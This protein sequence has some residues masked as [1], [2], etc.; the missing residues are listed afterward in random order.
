MTM[1]R[2]LVLALAILF[3][4]PVFADESSHD[5]AGPAAQPAPQQLYGGLGDVH[6]PVTTKSAQAQKYFDEGLA[7]NY[8]FN[9]NEAYQSFAAAAALDPKMAMANWGIALVFGPNYNL[10]G[11]DE[12]MKIA[13]G[14]IQRAQ[15]LEASANP[16]EKALIEALAKRYG[17]DGKQTPQREKA[18]A[19][20]MRSVANKYP[21][22]PDVQ[23][24]FAESLMDL[25]PWELWG[26][27]GKPGPQTLELVDT[28]E[29]TLKKHPNHLG[30]NHYYIHAVEAS[31][32]PERALPSAKRLAALAPTQGHLVHMPSHIYVR[33]G[34]YHEASSANEAA[35]KSDQS[36]LAESHESGVYPVMYATHNFDFLLYGEM[37]EG[38]KRDALKT[39][40][41]LKDA[42]PAAVIKEMPMGEVMWP[43]PYFAMARFGAW[44]EI[45]AE[46]APPKELAYTTAMWHYA[47]GLA[48]AAKGKIEDANAERKAL[49]DGAASV[50]AGLM[51]GP[52]NKAPA[53]TKLASQVLAGAIASARGDHDEALRDFTEAVRLQDA[54]GYD[55]PPSWYYPV[56]ETL[57]AELLA[58]KKAGMAEAVYR[59]DLKRNPDN[60]RSLYG[61]AESLRAQGK[62]EEAAKVEERFIKGW[63]HADITLAPEK[64]AAQ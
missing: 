43:K 58:N 61:L 63:S 25:H 52:N 64:V 40:R 45:L 35:I 9:H 5:H 47:R 34:M 46:L 37:M 29:R 4:A 27:D 26:A 28:L 17:P 22:D 39:A 18:Y 60:P 50:A 8:G 36:F 21:D 6:H 56:R 54:L 33:T 20:A 15:S 49:D 24:L 10:P 1:R 30:A 13:Y 38:R 62:A 19:D 16:E 12:R 11:N 59:D 42:V 2:S 32:H 51:V 48:F 23:A 57:G 31:P 41:D 53:I 7:F 44:D 55:E 3:A 14:A